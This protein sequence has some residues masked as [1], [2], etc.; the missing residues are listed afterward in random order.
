M[1]NFEARRFKLSIIAGAV[2]TAVCCVADQLGWLSAL[3]DWFYDER[4]LACQVFTRRPDDRIVHLDIDNASLET[5]AIGRWPWPRRVMGRII[6]EIGR[7]KPAAVAMDIQ[8]TDVDKTAETDAVDANTPIASQDD[9]ALEKALASQDHLVLATSFQLKLPPAFTPLTRFALDQLSRNLELTYSDFAR[10]ARTSGQDSGADLQDPYAVALKQAIHDRVCTELNRAAI[11]DDA[12]LSLLLPHT[13]ATVV[14]PARQHVLEEAKAWRDRQAFRQFGVEVPK[15]STPVVPCDFDTIPLPIF[16]K[17]AGSCGFVNCDLFPSA[18][19]R[20]L[21]MLVEADNRLYP[22]FGLAFGCAIIGADFHKARVEAHRLIIPKPD[23]TAVEIP[24]HEVY[25]QTLKRNFAGIAD[26]SWF[27][28]GDWFTMYDWPNHREKK[29]H[30]SLNTV[31]DI[32]KTA[33]KIRRNNRIFDLA[34]ND[35]F[36]GQKLDPALAAQY[37][38]SP[39]PL[40]DT[41]ARQ[42]ISISALTKVQ[43]GIDHLSAIRIVDRTP[44]Q[45][46]QLDALLDAQ[47]ALS[48]G[49]NNKALIDQLNALRTNLAAR[50]AG[51][52]VMIGWTAEGDFD[53][54]HTSLHARCPGC[55]V[56]GAIA[57]AVI[58][59]RWYRRAPD[60]IG[61]FLILLC[62]G[63]V[64]W[65]VAKLHPV[66]ALV[67][68]A[69]LGVFYL[70]FN[71]YILYDFAKWI[72]PV[73]GP[74]TVIALVWSGG[75]L[76]RVILE[77]I[78]RNRVAT[79][80]AIINRE[81]ELA[82][83]VQAALIPKAPPLIPTLEA[84]GWTLAASTTGGDCYDLWQLSDGRLAILLADASGHGLAPAMVVSQVR[85][86]VRALSE[87]ELHPHE[88]LKRV[89]SR[90]GEDLEPGRFVT[91]FLGFISP[92][93]MLEYAS[94]A[95]GPQFWFT[96]N[97][98]E[99]HL[100]D[101]TGAPLGADTEWL[102]DDPLPPIQIPA[103]G[104]LIIFSDGIFEALNPKGELFG[105]DRLTDLLRHSLG[106]PGKA[107][108]H[109]IIA[110]VQ[111]WQETK[112]PADDQTIVIARRVP[113]KA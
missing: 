102:A 35:A 77:G 79:E 12:L 26:I 46:A 100:L 14:T 93:G 67:A 87:V 72:V 76:Q 44:A 33:D 111:T 48:V 16:S 41:D 78:E 39:P 1:S 47:Q 113:P 15:L 4:A 96:E 84:D 25:S 112:V 49:D 61:I 71:G 70:L 29:A 13:D 7:A 95:H 109:E 97:D 92:E 80:V 58:S 82:R 2:L 20:S 57:E 69:L 22:Q 10:L 107:I 90:V 55:V 91:A 8:F 43:A 105:L 68:T 83:K 45:E 74:I 66:R 60:W 99:L 40:D 103:T 89:N 18:T 110:Q 6:D 101:S 42:K 59:G 94:A 24:I 73:A 31:W 36:A 88:L 30:L 75:T 5:S 56:H 3:D 34:F 9:L 21:P 37:A 63:V 85:T 19:L 64:S 27:G 38:A 11:G 51:K 23:G 106:K 108:I 81:M 98:P 65:C 62:G 104:S 17:H 53:V 28:T 32:C 50:L 86:L 52:G 54:V